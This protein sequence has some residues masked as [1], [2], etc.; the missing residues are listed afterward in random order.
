ME[1][2][3]PVGLFHGV[4]TLLQISML[5]HAVGRLR[6]AFD[7]GGLADSAGRLEKLLA[8]DEA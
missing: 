8:E 4:S 3:D 1:A 6:L 5:Q 7:A 2:A